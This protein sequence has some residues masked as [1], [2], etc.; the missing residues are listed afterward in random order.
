MKEITWKID[1][2]L[3]IAQEMKDVLNELFILYH[4]ELFQ[5][6]ESIQILLLVLGNRS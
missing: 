5:L 2:R 4:S 6:Q 3:F 1:L